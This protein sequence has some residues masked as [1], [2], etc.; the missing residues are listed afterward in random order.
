MVIILSPKAE[1]KV[2]KH[3]QNKQPATI[4][5]KYKGAVA[6]DWGIHVIDYVLFPIANNSAQVNKLTLHELSG[7]EYKAWSQ[8]QGQGR[9]QAG[10]E[11]GARG[12]KSHAVLE[13]DGQYAPIFNERRK[14]VVVEMDKRHDRH[15]S[16]SPWSNSHRVDITFA[17]D[18]FVKQWMAFEERIRNNK[19][20]RP[21]DASFGKAVPTCKICGRYKSHGSVFGFNRLTNQ[22]VQ[23]WEREFVC[24]ACTG[25]FAALADHVRRQLETGRWQTGEN[26]ML[27]QVMLK[28]AEDALDDPLAIATA[29]TYMGMLLDDARG[30]AMLEAARAFLKR[31]DEPGFA[32]ATC[33]DQMEHVYQQNMFFL[34]QRYS[35]SDMFEKAIPLLQEGLEYDEKEGNKLNIAKSKSSLASAYVSMRQYDKAEPLLVDSLQ[36]RKEVGGDPVPALLML[37]Q[38]YME[39]GDRDGA[40]KYLPELKSRLGSAVDR[41]PGLRQLMA[42]IDHFMKGGKVTRGGNSTSVFF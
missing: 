5:E 42:A 6:I 22:P 15:P 21:E 32:D 8:G 10:N 30:I 19:N 17:D 12:G 16:L 35:S 37:V 33:I 28:L 4:V 38:M 18:S 27:C 26:L 13:L 20:V 39:K 36:L 14:N 31:K 41:N 40:G 25:H 2:F 3:D 29:K 9:A 1:I 23:D 34:G 7:D 24:A 11:T